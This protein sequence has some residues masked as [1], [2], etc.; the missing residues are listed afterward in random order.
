MRRTVAPSPRRPASA[1]ARRQPPHRSEIS[2]PPRGADVPLR[3]PPGP[4]VTTPGRARADADSLALFELKAFIRVFMPHSLW[5]DR[6]ERRTSVASCRACVSTTA[7]PRPSLT[8]RPNAV[9]STRRASSCIATPR[10]EQWRDQTIPL[11]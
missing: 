1:R 11:A 3:L 8:H 9:A 6:W 5:R 10:A 7:R 2:Q 4:D